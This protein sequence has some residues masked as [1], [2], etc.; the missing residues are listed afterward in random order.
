MC[1]NKEKEVLILCCG[2]WIKDGGMAS[3]GEI[4]GCARGPGR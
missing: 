1:S 4:C 3:S 2:R